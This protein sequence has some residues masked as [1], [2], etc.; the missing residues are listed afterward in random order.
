LVQPPSTEHHRRDDRADV[1]LEQVGAHARDVADVVAD[2][3]RDD[4]RVARVVLGDA[5][6]DLA[7][8][9]GADVGGLRVDAAADAREQRDRGGAENNVMDM[10]GTR[11]SRGVRTDGW[12]LRV[13]RPG[14]KKAGQLIPHLE[15]GQAADRD[16]FGTRTPET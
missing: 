4:G 7:D 2:V 12:G 6:F 14:R 11:V 3:V 9:V 15:G 1:R 16:S 8:E 10:T 5:G 13:A